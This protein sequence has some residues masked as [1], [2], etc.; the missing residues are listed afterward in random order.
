[1]SQLKQI[2]LYQDKRLVGYAKLREI[3]ELFSLDGPP[4]AGEQNEPVVVRL[5]H[6]WVG[7]SHF[8]VH[9]ADIVREFMPR[10]WK[11]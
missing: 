9:T 4:D 1:M 2:P 3:A 6:P 7:G 11:P 10:R 5:K 8:V